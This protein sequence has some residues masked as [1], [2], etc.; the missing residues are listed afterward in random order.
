MIPTVFALGSNL[1]DRLAHLQAAVDRLAAAGRSVRASP[2][3]ETEPVGGP[4]QPA[5]LNAVL[6]LELPA[7]VD[8]LALAQG[9]EQA[10]GR[11][12]SVRWGP[13]TLDVDVVVRADLVSADPRLTLPHP[14]AHERAFVLVPWL[15]LDPAAVL[16]GTGPARLLLAGLGPAGVGTVRRR[17]DL[18]LT[19]PS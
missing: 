10:S 7:A 6:A 14:R 15:E 16:P 1:G 13:R 17:D 2:V 12:R 19:V 9:A 4:E 8:P 3:Y 11:D 5:Y 18:R